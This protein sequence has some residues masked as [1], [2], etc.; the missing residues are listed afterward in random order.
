MARLDTTVTV[1]DAFNIYTNLDTAE[2]LS[3]RYGDDIV[4]EDE[5]TI[6][7][8]LVDQ[9]EF[10]DVL[11]I[12]KTD[13]IDAPRLQ[14]IKHLLTLLNPSAK[15]L[16]SKYSKV[17]VREIISTGRFDFLKAASGAGW[18][19]SLH[20]MTVQKTGNGDRMA[21]KPETL[22]Y[23]LSILFMC[24]RMLML[25]D[26]GLITLSTRRDGR[27]ILG[28]CGICC[29]ISLFFFSMVMEKTRKMKRTKRVRMKKKTRTK[30]KRK[31]KKT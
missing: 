8:L 28:N 29:M 12:N 19:R 6:S 1:L 20:E 21:P 9:I 2:F 26:M 25:A 13:M 11:I 31:K 15:V 17:D 27:S 24:G 5:R 7:D 30:K 4:P 16:E 18:L 22:E 23:V 14:R 3:D 10:A